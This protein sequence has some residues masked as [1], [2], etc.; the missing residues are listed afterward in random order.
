MKGAALKPME[1]IQGIFSLRDEDLS[2]LS[3]LKI[4]EI[5]NS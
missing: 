2:G 1:I 5:L 3:V 4:G